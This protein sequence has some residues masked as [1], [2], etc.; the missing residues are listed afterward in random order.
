MIG[1]R[2]PSEPERLRLPERLRSVFWL[3]GRRYEYIC[4][5]SAPVRCLRAWG[6]IVPK[7]VPER[8]V[9]S[10][11]RPRRS[12][13]RDERDEANEARISQERKLRL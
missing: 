11:G 8:C 7:G 2:V 5:G 12:G 3:L 9:Q 6:E 1:S 4:S 10:S 13:D